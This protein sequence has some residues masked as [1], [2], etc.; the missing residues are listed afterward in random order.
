MTWVNNDGLKVKQ[1]A[2]EVTVVNGGSYR[3]HGSVMTSEVE[4]DLSLLTAGTAKTF[5]N[6]QLPKGAVIESVSVVVGDTVAAGG[7]SLDVG[8]IQTDH[9]TVV[10]ADGF[11]AA[12]ATAAMNA[13]GETT[14]GAGALVGTELAQAGFLTA[15]AT[16]TFTAGKV[17]VRFNYRYTG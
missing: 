5:D 14:A 11:V 3:H 12:I 6:V 16:G 4:I 15:T 9:A 7:T 17:S 10:D 13:V 2:E 8:L 1:G